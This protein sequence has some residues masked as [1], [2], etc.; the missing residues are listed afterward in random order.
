[1][2]R[3]AV[4]LA[5]G[6]EEIEAVTIVDVLRRGGIHVTTFS[7]TGT[8]EVNGSHQIIIRADQLFEEVDFAAYDM[9]V[10]PGGMPGAMNLNNHSGLKE[11]LLRMKSAGKYLGAICA[12]PLV[13]GNLGMVDGI[14]VT[15]YPGF[16]KY[17]QG[18]KL[19]DVGVVADQKVITG[20]GAGYA[21]EFSIRLL[22]ILCGESAAKNIADKMLAE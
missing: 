12:A 8:R 20:R 9:I 13:L 21:L 5:E 11:V 6:F 14:A 3:V 17:L 1:M 2:K 19:K 16:E 15:C 10:L 7:V 18:A 4:P 22:E